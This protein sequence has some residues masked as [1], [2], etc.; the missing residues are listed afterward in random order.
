MLNGIEHLSMADTEVSV[1]IPLH[2]SRKL[3]EICLRK[4]C[5]QTLPPKLFE[6]IVVDDNS[7]DGSAEAVHALSEGLPF[8]FRLVRR[9]ANEGPGAA[10]N[11]GIEAAVSPLIALLDADTEPSPQWLEE[12]LAAMD[13]FDAL[14]GHTA[15]GDPHEITPFTHQTENTAG[16]TFPTCNMFV[17]RTVFD[18]VGLFD[19]RFYDRAARVHYREDTD[20]A[21]RILEDGMRIG[22]ADKAVVVH[23]PLSPSWKR[24]FSLAKRYRHDRLLRR[25]HPQTF[26]QWTDVY[27]IFGLRLGR[28]RQKLYWGYLLGCGLIVADLLTG[29]PVWPAV[30]WTAVCLGGIWWLH[31]RRMGKRALVAA[32]A[33]QALPVVSLVP[34]VF[35]FSV[36]RGV[37]LHR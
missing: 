10:R 26:G 20:F 3:V 19:T 22:F 18:R 35:M 2:N 9:T 32:S 30:L 34:F 11:S 14:E 16:G 17:R 33:W 13:G 23:K 1:V 25:L 5:Q 12:G 36:I 7:T 31:V 8:A 28:L 4:L 27:R 21:L 37:W 29:W 6:V 15:I 24:P